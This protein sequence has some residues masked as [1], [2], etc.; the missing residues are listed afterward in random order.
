MDRYLGIF[1]RLGFREKL[2]VVLGLILLVYLVM[3][4]GFISP[5]QK[6]IKSLKAELAKV[7]LESET[8]RADMIVV[9]AQLEKDPFAKDRAQLD[10]FRKAIEEADAFLAK[11]QSDPRQ[12]GQ[13]LRQILAGS[14]GLSLV[15]VRTLVA[16][17]II[18]PA[19][20]A[21]AAGGK[22]T[23]RIV[24]RRGIE[25]TIRGNYL[26]ILPFLQRL[27]DQPTR[28]LWGEAELSVGTYPE[29][30]MRLTFYT[31]NDVQMVPLG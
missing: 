20:T 13:L 4:F 26:A 31:V 1:N 25:L 8:V 11:V 3:D 5:Q 19:K 9:K 17:P 27:Q 2:G 7:T 23:G 30:T 14:P 24:Y 21:Q 15:S 28:L 10:A 12:V 6:R 22:G 29:S 18:D 16:V